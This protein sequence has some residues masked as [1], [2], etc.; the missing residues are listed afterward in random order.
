[1]KSQGVPRKPGQHFVCMS[2]G[3]EDRIEDVGNS[4]LPQNKRETFDE[5]FVVDL[6][7]WKSKWR[8]L[9]ARQMLAGAI[10]NRRRKVFRK[11]PKIWCL[12]CSRDCL[13]GH[14]F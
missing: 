13:Q 4:P 3:G 1:M 8:Y 11:L 6:E 7:G 9:H 5:Y 14:Q 2:V 10:I 12:H